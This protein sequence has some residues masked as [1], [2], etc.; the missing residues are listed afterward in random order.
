MYE[1]YIYVT[2]VHS[3][4]EVAV[5]IS[6]TFTVTDLFLTMHVF[7]YPIYKNNS[8]AFCPNFYVYR[9]SYMSGHLI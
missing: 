8:L 2:S 7:I 5:N 4:I 1:P 6:E 9:G 3:L